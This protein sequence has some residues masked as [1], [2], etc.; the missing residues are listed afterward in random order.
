MLIAGLEKNS[1]VDYPGIISAV[2]FTKGCNMN[3]YYCHNRSI[4]C[5]ENQEDNFETGYV[6]DFLH[7][8]RNFLEGVVISGGE[9]TLHLGL[10][11][12][13]KDI[14]DIGYKIKL[15]TNGTNPILL[16][17]IIDKALV[18]YIAMDIKAPYEKYNDVCGIEI[19]IEKIKKSI[20]IIRKSKIEYEFRT[21]LVPELTEDDVYS[22][23]ESIEDANTYVL[24][25]FRTYNNKIRKK[26]KELLP[27]SSE[28]IKMLS[29][30]LKGKFNTCYVRGIS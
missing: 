17:K 21:T 13:L 10:E 5:P 1:F 8:R 19:N 11:N 2:V 9:P 3:C 24:Q 27:H 15:D 28:F 23:V 25:Q 30:R 4:I 12:F 18:D 14:K 7:S 6:L 16:Q 20:E 26:N 29:E 22:I